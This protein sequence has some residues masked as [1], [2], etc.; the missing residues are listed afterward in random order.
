MG[1]ILNKFVVNYWES[2][3]VAERYVYL[4][5][6]NVSPGWYYKPKNM[7]YFLGYGI[8]KDKLRLFLKKYVAK[9]GEKALFLDNN[10]VL[11]QNIIDFIKGR[12]RV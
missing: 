7:R 6:D 10:P 9:F 3:L 5:K 2:S 12:E 11:K 8:H 4:I 1:K